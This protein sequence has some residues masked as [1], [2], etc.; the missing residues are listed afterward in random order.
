MPCHKFVIIQRF[1][2]DLTGFPIYIGNITY[3]LSS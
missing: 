1:S 2:I 3:S